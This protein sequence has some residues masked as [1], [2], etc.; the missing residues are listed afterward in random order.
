[1]ARIGALVATQPYR[2]AVAVTPSDVTELA[3]TDAI[4]IGGDGSLVVTMDNGSDATFAGMVAGTGLELR[5]TKVKA[6]STA[7]NILALYL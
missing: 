4:Y 1:M 2:S 3:H 6:A 5:V 7:T